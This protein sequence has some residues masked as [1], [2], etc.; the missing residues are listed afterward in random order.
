MFWNPCRHQVFG[1]LK[2][3]SLCFMLFF[4]SSPVA[5]LCP[6]PRGGASIKWL[7][8]STCICSS[9]FL[10]VDV[11]LDPE[12]A[13][14][15]FME[16]QSQYAWSYQMWFGLKI[17]TKVLRRT[18]GHN[19]VTGKNKIV[20]LHPW[21]LSC[22]KAKESRPSEGFS[23]SEVQH[24]CL[25]YSFQSPLK[26]GREL[27]WGVGL[28]VQ[29]PG[30]APPNISVRLAEPQKQRLDEG[31]LRVA[32]EA[33]WIRKIPAQYF[34]FFNIFLFSF[35]VVFSG[36]WPMFE[37]KTTQSHVLA[38]FLYLENLDLLIATKCLKTVKTWAIFT[39]VEKR[40]NVEP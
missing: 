3:I 10:H 4:V 6:H 17:K 8:F 30:G 5:V 39:H 24:K 21:S 27:S 38:F 29:A 25:R 32:A 34:S 28:G 36:C 14:L 1:C 12:D 19:K 35:E 13:W 31:T 33:N 11:C 37:L 16:F 18:G 15:V 9:A 23:L 7:L 26:P 20:L 2:C 40:V 22:K